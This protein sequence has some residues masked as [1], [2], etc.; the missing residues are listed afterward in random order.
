M[1]IHIFGS[2]SPAYFIHVTFSYLVTIVKS[3]GQLTPDCTDSTIVGRIT[4]IDMVIPFLLPP[5]LCI[6]NFMFNEHAIVM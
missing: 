2:G 3:V 1:N 4:P 5:S 6:S